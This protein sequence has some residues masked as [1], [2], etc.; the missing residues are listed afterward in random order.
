[1]IF[2]QEEDFWRARIW[3]PVTLLCHSTSAGLRSATR[4]PF[5]FK[6]YLDV[7]DAENRHLNV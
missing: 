3:G 7:L 4:P 2:L 6:Q 5:L 1:V